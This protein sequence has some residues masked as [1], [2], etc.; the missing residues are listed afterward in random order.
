M[1]AGP[2]AQVLLGRQLVEVP[3]VIRP[4]EPEDAKRAFQAPGHSDELVQFVPVELPEGKEGVVA[5]PEPDETNKA[6]LAEPGEPFAPLLPVYKQLPAEE[7]DQADWPPLGTYGPNGRLVWHPDQLSAKEERQAEQRRAKEERRLEK[8][9][10]KEE[11]E[12]AKK[13]A[14]EERELAKKSAK[15]E[16][17]RQKA[18]RKAAADE[19]QSLLGTAEDADQAGRSSPGKFCY[20]CLGFGDTTVPL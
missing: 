11:K 5:F 3:F 10:L 19:K 14:R 18:A 8:Q 4:A 20:P 17:E 6:L 13:R 2:P 7:T 16:R 9:R 12:L 1:L 15:E